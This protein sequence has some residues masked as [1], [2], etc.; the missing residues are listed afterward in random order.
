MV[1]NGINHKKNPGKNKHVEAKQHDTKQPIGQ[2]SNQ[3]RSKKLHGDKWKWKHSSP[4][5]LECSENSSKRE[6]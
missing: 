4:K 2:R 5:S 1:W 3:R 6:T